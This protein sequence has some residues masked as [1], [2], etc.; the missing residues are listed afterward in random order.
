M[1]TSSKKSARRKSWRNFILS[2]LLLIIVVAAIR[3]WQQRDVASGMAP[4]LVGVKLDG[5]AYALPVKPAQP[6]LVHFWAS[7]CGICRAQ[8][9][10]ID[11]IALGYP[12]TITIAIQSGSDAEVGRH[13]V[14]QGLHFSVLNDTYGQLSAAWGV[15]GVPTTFIISQDGQ[16]RF[17]EVGYTTSLG[18]RLRLWLAEKLA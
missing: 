5:N 11:A 15:Q 4:R 13:L 1:N 16:I 18:L 7:W 2:L 12:N 9:G 10:S 17:T 3:A 6:V 8:Q 14:E